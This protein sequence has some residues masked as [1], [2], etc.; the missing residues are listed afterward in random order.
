MLIVG[1]LI[2][3]MIILPKTIDIP[4]YNQIRSLLHLYLEAESACF[5]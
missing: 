3:L 2:Y 5:L 1:L 4:Q